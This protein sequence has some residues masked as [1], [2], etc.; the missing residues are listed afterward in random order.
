MKKISLSGINIGKVREIGL[1]MFIILLSIGVQIRNDNFLTLENINDLVTNTAILSILAIGMMLVI[2]TRGIDLSIGATLALSGM[3]AALMV[4][5]NPEMNPVLVILV[6][7][8]IGT[9]CGAIVGGLI[10]KVNILPIIATLGLMNVFRG[11]TFII[12]GGKWVS[13]HQMPVS[14]KAIAT[15]KILGINTLI[16]IAI[17]IYIIFYYFINHTR[18]GRQIYA[19]GSNPDSAKISGINTDRIIWM[20]YT[21]MGGLSGLAGVLWV[22]KFA[23]AQGDTAS[24]YELNVIAA[25][26]LG[27][28]AISGGIGKISGLLMGTLLLGI[29]NNALP[30]INVS[31]FWQNAIQGVVILA[32][33]IMN[34]LIKRNV[35]ANNLRRRKI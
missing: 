34:A 1:L 27:G 3:S 9:V 21:I 24:G 16:F 8:L 10:A 11:F 6:G 4:S 33:V 20:V 30:L 29:L 12:S 28:V 23:S 7:I 17:I 13:A 35:D 25:C 5:N 19:T 15:G 31:P 2:I 18:T 14:F 26:V 32:A 22:S